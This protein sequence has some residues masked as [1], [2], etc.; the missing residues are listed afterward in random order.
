MSAG[1]VVLLALFEV[2]KGHTDQPAVLEA[3]R[4][5]LGLMLQLMAAGER[6]WQD[7]SQQQLARLDSA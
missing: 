3:V 7:T 2:L 6:C 1:S 5:C 4:R